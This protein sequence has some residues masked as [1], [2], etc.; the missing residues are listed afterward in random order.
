MRH[1]FDPCP[2]QVAFRFQ[3]GA[4]ARSL[5][6]FRRV[7]SNAPADVVQ[8]H[9]GHYHLWVR[10][11]LQDA[12]LADRLKQEGERSRD[13]ETLR[14]SLDTVLERALQ[15]TPSM[16]QPAFGTRARR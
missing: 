8:F 11:I 16:P 2:D 9:R 14:R 10:D 15:D 4:Q 13:G 3:H 6:E 12:Q 5:D 1:A 7:L